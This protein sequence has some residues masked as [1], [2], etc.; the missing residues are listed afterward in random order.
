M[1]FYLGGSHDRMRLNVAQKVSHGEHEQLSALFKGA[2]VY[3]EPSL[4]VLTH[5]LQTRGDE[6]HFFKKSNRDN[7]LVSHSPLG[8]E[9]KL[10]SFLFQ[11]TWHR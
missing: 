6:I 1:L 8:C 9:I 10:L 4:R 7:S 11:S 3:V 2:R 5:L